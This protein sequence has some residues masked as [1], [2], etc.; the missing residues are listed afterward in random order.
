MENKDGVVYLENGKLTIINPEGLGRY[1]RITAGENVE[2]YIDG[3]K[4]N[5]E[6]VV[7]QDIECLIEFKINNINKSKKL[8]LEIT[9]DKLKAFLIIEI[10]PEQILEIQDTEPANH[11]KIDT[12][13]K[14]KIFPEVNKK[15]II[16]LLNV[17]NISYGIKHNYISQLLKQNGDLNGK[18]LIAEGKKAEAGQNA[19]IIK[20][21]EYKKK[22]ENLFNVIDSIDKGETICY[23]K[24]AVPGKAGVN[25]FSEKISPPTVKDINLKQGEMYS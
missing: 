25:V 1:P 7:S 18:Y 3:V 24:E 6:I 16:E 5:N 22:D 19:E 23:K 20:S 11:I 12:K 17:H 8:D 10:I 9:E 13:I 2:I 15:E 4:D 21:E 14:E